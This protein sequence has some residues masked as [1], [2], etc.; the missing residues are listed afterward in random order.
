MQAHRQAGICSCSA[1]D[2]GTSLPWRLAGLEYVTGQQLQPIIF[3][4][5]NRQQLQATLTA[6]NTTQ[7]QQP[8]AT[9]NTINATSRPKPPQTHA[10]KLRQPTSPIA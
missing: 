1:P 6:S 9:A 2:L 10:H 4:N 8:T 7:E 5:N 3:A